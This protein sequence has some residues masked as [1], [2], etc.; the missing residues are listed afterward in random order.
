M[1]AAALTVALALPLLGP[2]S[3]DDTTGTV[4]PLVH[5]TQAYSGSLGIGGDVQDGLLDFGYLVPGAEPITRT[6]ALNVTATANWHVT[7][8]TIQDLTVGGGGDSIPPDVFTFTSGGD[9]GP[10]YVTSET[11]FRT[12]GDSEGNQVTVDVASSD[13]PVE[14]CQVDVDYSLEI[15]VTQ[16]DGYYS[17]G[18]HVYTLIVGE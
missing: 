17:A 11:P 9:L 12:S 5:V 18:S 15:P 14:D 6:V 2:V 13:L 16:A 7:L 10:T 4:T 8:T 1:A 3:A